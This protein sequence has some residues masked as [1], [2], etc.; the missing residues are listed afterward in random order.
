MIYKNKKILF[1]TLVCIFSLHSKPTSKFYRV[2]TTADVIGT[3]LKHKLAGTFYKNRNI[4]NPPFIEDKRVLS[5]DRT[6]K[7]DGWADP[8]EFYKDPKFR[9]LTRK[10]LSGNLLY[11][12]EGKP[13]NPMGETG[14]NGRGILGKWGVNLAADPIITRTNPKTKKL[15]MLA[16]KRKDN[17]QWAIP[18]GM[19]DDGDSVSTTLAKELKEETGILIPENFMKHALLIYQGYVDDPRNTNNAWIE[20][21]VR[22][23]KLNSNNSLEK[24]ISQ[25]NLTAGDDATHA[26]WKEL[27]PEFIRSLY[28]SHPIFVKEVLELSK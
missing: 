23:K 2:L 22:W 13:L 20:T 4:N 12:A 1:L 11:N 8:P 3:A 9:E 21:V 10:S 18:G 24:D 17:E 19:V 26:Q 27:N 14:V 7:K 28:A 5:N 15:E 16:I 25:M 6:I